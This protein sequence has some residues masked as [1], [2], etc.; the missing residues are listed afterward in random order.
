MRAFLNLLAIV[1]AITQKSSRKDIHIYANAVKNYCIGVV[2]LLYLFLLKT[3]FR[4]SP[5]VKKQLPK[6]VCSLDKGFQ[7]EIEMEISQKK[8]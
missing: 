2:F 3:L 7:M 6:T 8:N 1:H 4:F 5:S